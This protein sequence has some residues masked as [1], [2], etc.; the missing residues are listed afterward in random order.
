VIYIFLDQE[1]IDSRD[2]YRSGIFDLVLDED[3]AFHRMR[4]EN[5][6]LLLEHFER[7]GGRIARLLDIG[8]GLGHF[9]EVVS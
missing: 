4:I 8:C 6:L 3:S 7:S 1:E 9:L 2:K 5:T